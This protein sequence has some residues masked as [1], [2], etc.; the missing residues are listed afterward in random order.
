M[1]RVGLRMTQVLGLCIVC[2]QMTQMTQML[3]L[4]DV[5]GRVGRWVPDRC[6]A[7]RF[8]ARARLRR[9]PR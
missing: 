8:N 7:A 5:V 3:L 1:T 6:E 4:Y 2:P 9:H